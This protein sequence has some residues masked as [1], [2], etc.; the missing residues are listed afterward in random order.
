MVPNTGPMV[1]VLL[2]AAMVAIGALTGIFASLFFVAASFMWPTAL[3]WAWAP[4]L[5]G[6]VLGL[7][8]GHW[9]TKRECK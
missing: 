4:P 8:A 2:Y 1:E 5:A 7:F 9:I 3:A 6:A